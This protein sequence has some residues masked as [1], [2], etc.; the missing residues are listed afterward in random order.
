M[1]GGT[2]DLTQLWSHIVISSFLCAGRCVSVPLAVL[3]SCCPKICTLSGSLNNLRHLL[4]G[5]PEVKLS[6][7][8]SA[9][10]VQVQGT[11]RI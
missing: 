8:G 10:L 5:E 9:V 4:M 7:D 3:W 11:V 1:E 2:W 6:Q